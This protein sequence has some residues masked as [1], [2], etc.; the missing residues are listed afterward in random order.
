M[1]VR[2]NPRRFKRSASFEAF[3]RDF[4]R[5]WALE[6]APCQESALI[7]LR[8]EVLRMTMLRSSDYLDLQ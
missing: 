6:Q 8:S 3:Y 7:Q 2:F 1:T 5:E 4:V